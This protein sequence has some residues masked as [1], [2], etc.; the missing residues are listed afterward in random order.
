M[1]GLYLGMARGRMGPA[2]AVLDG[3]R[4]AVG[5]C[6]E[7][8]LTRARVATPGRPDLAIAELLEFLH[9][10]LDDVTSVSVVTGA[11]QREWPQETS[12]LAVDAGLAHAAYAFRASPFA[13][14]LV[15]VCDVHSPR[16]W[17]AWRFSRTRPPEPVGDAL[18]AYPLARIYGEL[19][20]ALGFVR[21]RDEHLVEAL[22]RTGRD[23]PSRIT[24]HLT[25]TSEGVGITSGF[26]EDI[27]QLIATSPGQK[28]HIAA[29]VQRRLGECLAELLIRLA[30][31]G[32]PT[33]EP[34]ALCVSGGLFF[35]TYF[36]TVAA[37]CG[38]FDQVHVPAHP[39]RNGAAM[40]AALVAGAD[41]EIASTEVGSPYLGP[42]YTSTH[43]KEDL[44]NCKL[45][46]D[47]LHDE[48][49]LDDVVRAL[50]GGRLIG[51]FHDRLEWG[52][53]ALGHRSVLADPLAPHTLDNLNGFLKRRPAY[54]SYGV[55]VPLAAVHEWFEGPAESPFMQFEYR[56]RD[57]ER[58]RMILP[59]GV[60]RLRVHTVDES[61]P[62][63]LRLL[64][65][66]G[67][68]TGT[69]VLV[70]T[71]FNGF[72]EPLVCSPRDAIRVFYGTGLDMVALENFVLHK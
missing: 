38:A 64:T 61:Q 11:H 4:G 56:P 34:G 67:E 57:P 58:F 18:G 53:R 13:E 70:N 51:W 2:A 46:Y 28:K 72:H 31:L 19:T 9:L 10:H 44:D 48:R 22:A 66:W 16:G 50:A 15:L 23:A 63:F 14:A 1:A 39:G 69:P 25:S 35:N 37:T 27:R 7:N 71:S 33:A 42:A 47:L 45:S 30:G 55:S 68:R 24:D 32:P 6:E 17:A 65:W 26:A 41:S 12:A 29:S 20:D 40:G 60:E 59:P 49:L 3:R 52:P 54:R 21:A 8:R 43:I 36:T 62:R 5:A